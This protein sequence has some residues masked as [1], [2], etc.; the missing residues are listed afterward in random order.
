MVSSTANKVWNGIKGLFKG[1]FFHILTGN[2]FNKAVAMIS[3]VVIAR[4]VDKVS[5]AH[6]SY[7]D[8]IYSYITLFSG[9]GMSSA[10]L[11]FCSVDNEKAKNAA[12]LKFAYK[13]GGSFELAA[14]LIACI[15]LT[16]F[17]IP[18]TRARVFAW[19]LV[20]YPL[21]SYFITTNAVYMRTQLDNKKY[22]VSG[23]A[24][25][26]FSCLFSVVGIVLLDT[27]GIVAGRYLATLLILIYTVMYVRK[28]L[29]G[30]DKVK[31][32][33]QEKKAFFSMGISLALANFFSGIMPINETFLVNNIIRDETIS[34]NFRVAGL[35]PQ[36]LLLISG[37]ITVYYFP[38]VARLKNGKEIKT[39]VLRIAGINFAVI[40]VVTVLG[41]LLTPWILDF[42]Y[43]GKYNDAVGIA[44]VLWL[45]RASN[46]VI[47]FVPMNMLPAIGKVKFNSATAI[48]SC[49]AQCG[50]D[51]FFINRFGIIG[52]A[53]GAIIVY[54]ISG[55]AYWIYFLQCVR[56]YVV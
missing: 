32:S 49:I 36:M 3:S 41:M 16:V 7:A 37:A 2:V 35:I 51:Y 42:L 5:Y 23:V 43:D 19:M 1:G 44:Y 18:Y 12:Y 31:L 17:D 11:K 33:S 48:I 14:S 15:A 13:V 4:L 38:I 28:K 50:L 9:L 34:A 24:S 53:Y 55:I 30:T 39:K 10:L 47:R 40:G 21:L 46:C 26:V 27:K 54:L 6:L 25:S 20:F 22:A 29:A 8:N 52:A 45:M 56:K